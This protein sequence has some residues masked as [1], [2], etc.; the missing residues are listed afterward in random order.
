[1]YSVTK[2]ITIFLSNIPN[3][4][5]TLEKQIDCCQFVFMFKYYCLHCKEEYGQC[6]K[7]HSL[8]YSRI[9][10]QHHSKKFII[11]NWNCD[12]ERLVCNISLYY[13][14]F[15]F[16]LWSMTDHLNAKCFSKWQSVLASFLT[17]KIR[18][19]CL[20][21]NQ[22]NALFKIWGVVKLLDILKISLKPSNRSMSL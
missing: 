4:N 3:G 16:K 12:P 5:S 9:S 19:D 18:Y 22:K 1:M 20:F 7:V 17:I 13:R 10:L 21:Y 15:N 8:A 2:E 11:I 14:I 6:Q